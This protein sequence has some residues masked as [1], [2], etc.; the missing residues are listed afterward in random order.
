MAIKD[1]LVHMDDGERCKVSLALAAKLAAAHQGHLIGLNVR[2]RA[3]LSSYAAANLGSRFDS[4]QDGHNIEVARKAKASFDA[5]APAEGVTMEWRNVEGNQ[6]ETIATHAMY[7]DV[8][9][10]GQ[11]DQADGKRL[12]DSLIM[13]AGR[14]ILVVPKVGLFEN[15]GERVLVAWNASREA[16]R[17]VHD[18]MPI[19]TRAKVVRVAAGEP[20]GG[21]IHGENP[22]A[23]LS[24]HLKRHGVNVVWEHLHGEGHNVG[25]TLLKRTAQEGI[26]LIV[27]GGYGHS[28][29]REVV[30][31]GATRHIL[32]HMAVPVLMSH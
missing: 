4:T 13:V 24:A 5:G 20:E 17:A 9:V 32:N 26:D 11:E 31:G 2:T 23:D 8:T 12:C 3:E 10:I 22:G 21:A 1:I 27:M 19:L 28:R 7:S 16:T 29:F 25:E 18:A 14:P 30:L 6:L 15:I